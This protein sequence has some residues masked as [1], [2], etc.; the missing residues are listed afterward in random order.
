MSAKGFGFGYLSGTFGL[1]VMVVMLFTISGVTK[2]E[3]GIIGG[4]TSDE[5]FQVAQQY[6]QGVNGFRVWINDND[7][8]SGMQMKFNKFGWANM[9]G[10]N[11]TGERFESDET[12]T[13]NFGDVHVYTQNGQITGFSLF[14]GSQED[15]GNTSSDKEPN[16]TPSKQ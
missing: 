3:S 6:N 9:I 4:A 15:F 1:L 13:D 10:T 12:N 8:V 2:E 7:L 11:N 5:D 14:R 16:F